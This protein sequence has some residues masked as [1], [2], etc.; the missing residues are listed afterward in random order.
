MPGDRI[1]NNAIGAVQLK[2]NISISGNF[3]VGGHLPVGHS[4]PREKFDVKGNA[5]VEGGL[6]VV[7]IG[8][9]VCASM[10]PG[11]IYAKTTTV[12]AADYAEYFRSETTMK[13]G[14]VVGLN[15]F[16]G[17]VRNYHLGDQLVGVVSTNPGIIGGANRDPRTHALVALMGQV[18][19]NR[20]QVLIS[21]N[22]IYTHDNK[23]IGMLLTNGDMV[24]DMNGMSPRLIEKIRNQVDI[25]K[26]Q[27]VKIKELE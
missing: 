24:L 6:C 3:G 23:K 16:S 17:K 18:P 15:P 9:A 27:A 10:T 21:D 4:N 7:S 14:D 12:Q 26:R 11:T 1:A 22:V 5:V 8:Q 13:A 2:N 25:N 19:F 20:E